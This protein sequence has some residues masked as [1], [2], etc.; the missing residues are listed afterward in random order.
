MTYFLGSVCPKKD[1]FG[2]FNVAVQEQAEENWGVDN[3][4]S[5]KTEP[6]LRYLVCQFGHKWE[7]TS[8]TRHTNKADEITLGRYLGLDY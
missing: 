4:Y 1:C 2:R 8:L 7:L 5:I 3:P 6:R